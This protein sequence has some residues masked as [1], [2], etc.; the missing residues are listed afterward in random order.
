MSMCLCAGVGLDGDGFEHESYRKSSFVLGSEHTLFSI[1]EEFVPNAWDELPVLFSECLWRY[2][3][4]RQRGRTR[5]V[6][7]VMPLSRF[8]VHDMVAL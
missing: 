7:L 6:F 1:T 3:G 2:G 5:C 8:V 4:F